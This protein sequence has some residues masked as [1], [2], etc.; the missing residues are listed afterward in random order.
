MLRDTRIVSSN[1]VWKEKANNYSSN[2]SRIMKFAV[3][4][5]QPPYSSRNLL[6]LI[7]EKQRKII[8]AFA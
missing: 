7:K 6:M 8:Y 5:C 3:V 1:Y 4:H 2:A